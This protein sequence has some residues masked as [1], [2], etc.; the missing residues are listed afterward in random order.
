MQRDGLCFSFRLFLI[1]GCALC[2]VSA[3][4]ATPFAITATNVTM[5]TAGPTTN[6]SGDTSIPLG[7]SQITVTGI[8]AAGTLTIGCQYSGPAT[9]AKIP[10]QCGIVGPGQLQVQASET[11]ISG[12][13]YFVPYSQ[14]YVPG[15]AELP[16][17]PGPS[18]HLPTS[19]MALAGGLML[20]FGL[21]RRARRWLAFTVF[22]VFA[23]AGALGISA[24]GGSSAMTPEAYPYTISAG[25]TETGS[26]AIQTAA[27]TVLVTVQ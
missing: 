11:T 16:D 18:G 26:G 21:R 23:L 25:F 13:V 24:C 4:A 19:G 20:G 2:G 10:K 3:L 12:T 1:A 5:P 15:L 9:Q 6:S 27:T 7:V 22:A 8:P 17:A 14:G